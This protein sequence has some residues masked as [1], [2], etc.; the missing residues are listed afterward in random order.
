MDDARLMLDDATWDR[1]AAAIADA[2]SAA[3]AP[4]ALATAT[5][6]RPSCT[7]PAPA[8]P[9]RPARPLRRLGR[10]VPAV[11]PLGVN[12]TWSALF[13]AL[14]GDL[15]AVAALF[16]D[17]TVVRADQHAAGAPKKRGPILRR[18]S[19]GAGGA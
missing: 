9:A 6:S 1:F 3:G 7:A 15:Q 19:G 18:R 11:P 5:S 8:A 4:P 2:K 17:S 13:A 12:G 10:R 16:V 14:P